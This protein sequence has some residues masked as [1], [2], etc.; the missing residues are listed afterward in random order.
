MISESPPLR[1][2]RD[3]RIP[4]QVWPHQAE[5]VSSHT[6]SKEEFSSPGA[7]L[8]T[9]REN[10]DSPPAPL[11]TVSHFRWIHARPN[12][13]RSKTRPPLPQTWR[14]PF[15]GFEPLRRTRGRRRK[16]SERCRLVANTSRDGHHDTRT[17]NAARPCVKAAARLVH[18]E[19][20][21]VAGVLD[22]RGGSVEC[23]GL[24]FALSF[25]DARSHASATG[26]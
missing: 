15:Q 12:I 24:D 7:G 20:L 10:G 14:A 25:A 3:F 22:V 5:A 4:V 19:E 13:L 17:P 1:L 21:F 6:H 8:Y 18:G 9:G 16:T 11:G 23:E 26:P 2:G